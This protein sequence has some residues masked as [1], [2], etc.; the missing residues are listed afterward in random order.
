MS[1]DLFTVTPRQMKIL[2]SDCLESGLVPFVTGSPGIGKS[3][4]MQAIADEYALELI[5]HRISTSDPTD[6]NGLPNFQ[7][8]RATFS[9]FDLFPIEGTPLPEGKEGWMLFLDEFN[10]GELD[11]QK[12][13][14]KLVLDEKVGQYPLHERCV[15]TAAGNLIT[16]RAIVNELSTAMQSRL[17]HFQLRVDWD[18]WLQDVALKRNFDNRLITYLAR[19]KGSELMDFDPNHKE[20]TFCCPRTWEFVNRSLSKKPQLTDLDAILFAGTI[21]SGVAASFVQYTK[22]FQHI[23]SLKDILND[24]ENF[25]VHHTNEV[26]WATISMLMNH[27]EDKNF[28]KI[29]T[30]VDRLTLDF[31]ILFYRSIKIR[32]PKLHAH[33]AFRK[34][35]VNLAKYLSEE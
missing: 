27:V 24:P 15:I 19:N 34:A 6:F 13:C 20:R 4:I 3:A 2:V 25:S 35:F 17:V 32:T 28:E 23:P 7:D 18:E 29:T 30:Y 12:A 26:L 11:V 21:T 33:P 1:V 5:D 16:D 10:S 14:Y 31:R 9:P 22:V 8:N